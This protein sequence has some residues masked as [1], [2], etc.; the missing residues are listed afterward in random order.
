M[1]IFDSEGEYEAFLLDNAV[2]AVKTQRGAFY[3]QSDYGSE[4]YRINKEPKALYA[5]CAAR[6]ALL[7]QDGMYP[8]DARKTNTGYDFTVLLNGTERMVSVSF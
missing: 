5:L 6:R 1:F 3:P 8:V 4:V 7:S 2:R